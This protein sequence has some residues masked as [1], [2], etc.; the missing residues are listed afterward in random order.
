MKKV[1][2]IGGMMCGHCEARVKKI[3]ES[4]KEVDEA[5][6]SH[7]KGTAILTLNADLTDAE[8]KKAVEN[9]G[10]TFG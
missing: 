5:V 9:D 1:V 10:Y 2:K 4:F 6:V 8:I 3:L 7:K